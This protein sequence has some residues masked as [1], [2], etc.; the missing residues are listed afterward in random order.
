MDAP[1]AP[2]KSDR[3]ILHGALFFALAWMAGFIPACGTWPLPLFLPL[4][5]YV[6]IVIAISS[7][8][9]TA[10]AIR[11]GTYSGTAAVITSAITV[12]SV[13]ALV[14]FDVVARPNVEE[15]P[16]FLPVSALGGI[17]AAGILFSLLNPILEEVIFRGILFDAVRS[18]VGP[19]ATVIITAAL[20]GIAHMRGYPPG[21]AGAMLAFLYGIAM[22]GLRVLTGGLAMPMI[23]H[24]AADATIYVLIA[25]TGVFSR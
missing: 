7:L 22:G 5:G 12:I 15:Y 6:L 16:G 19:L 24:V 25:R 23:A 17:V 21:T 1:A 18:Q 9:A 4:I 11:F 2:P 20:F 13:G 14:A 3:A 8:R 10:P